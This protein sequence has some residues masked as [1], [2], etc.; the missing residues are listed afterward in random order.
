MNVV[1]N[2]LVDFLIFVCFRVCKYILTNLSSHYMLINV[3][4]YMCLQFCVRMF[5]YVCPIFSWFFFFVFIGVKYGK[6]VDFGNFLFFLDLFLTVYF[7]D[8]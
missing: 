7:R 8:L 5:S 6:L 4:C 1:L 3:V 2:G